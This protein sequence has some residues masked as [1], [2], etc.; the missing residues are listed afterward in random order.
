M[1]CYACL[2]EDTQVRLLC[3]EDVPSLLR[4]ALPP[5]WSKGNTVSWYPDDRNHNHPSRHWI[6]VVWRYLQEHF[7]TQEDI[8][9][10]VKLPL[11][12]LGMTQTPVPLA[13]LCSPSRVVVK[14]LNY[15][16]LDD[17][18]A[19][20]LKKLGL[21]IMNDFPPYLRHHPAVLGTL[22][23]PPS[24]HGVLK[25]MAISSGQMAA[26]TFSEIVRTTLSTN[27]KHL[28]R[29]FL[30]RVGLVGQPE[31]NLLCSLPI[32][33][34]LSKK[35]VSRKQGLCATVADSLPVSPLRELIDITQHDSETLA[36]LLDVRILTPTELLCQMVFPDIHRGQYSEKQ[37]DQ[38]MTY[39]LE[40]HAMEIR[41]NATFK[42]KLQALPF[43]SKHRGRARASELFDPRNALL[44][45]IFVNE[46]VFPTV[47]YAE[48]SIL[49]MK[50]NLE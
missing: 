44:K 45:N 32:F 3:E 38:L 26:G 9:R 20:V 42:Q 22:V 50:K 29:S 14:C 35:F 12:P 25:A 46:D 17:S 40:N 6:T 4:E 18:L 11:I 27:D 2:T 39:V 41:K 37:I 24:V 7:T 48:R 23:H 21:I 16:C 15:D 34:T 33:Q 31:Y 5:E 28:L 49:V 47:T 30:A 8:Q 1:C 13:R 43:V 36:V 19:N 10:L